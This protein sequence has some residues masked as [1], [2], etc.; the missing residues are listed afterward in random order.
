MRNL[1][2]AM[3]K[4]WQFAG[5]VVLTPAFVGHAAFSDDVAV[6]ADVQ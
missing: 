2:V 3:F 1:R 4:R 6:D 5:A